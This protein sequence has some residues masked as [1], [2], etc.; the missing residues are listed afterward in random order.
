M[1]EFWD[2]LVLVW[3]GVHKLDDP[4]AIIFGSAVGGGTLAAMRRLDAVRDSDSWRTSARRVFV[5]AMITGTVS[6]AAA[7][8][9][10]ELFPRYPKLVL[11]LIV[12]LSGV[13][14]TTTDDGRA[15]I[16][17]EFIGRLLAIY[18]AGRGVKYTPPRTLEPRSPA[19]NPGPELSTDAG[20]GN[21]TQPREGSTPSNGP[22]T[23]NKSAPRQTKKGPW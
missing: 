22:S 5:G 10:L 20:E 16:V 11:G 7:A 3:S 21:D 2:L 19:S 1:F 14:D 23:I 12:F 4:F 8:V 6:A 18:D 13:V 17:R 15:W 9:G